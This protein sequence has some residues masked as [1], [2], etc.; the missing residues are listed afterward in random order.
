MYSFVTAPRT[1]RRRCFPRR[2]PCR[3]MVPMVVSWLVTAWSLIPQPVSAAAPARPNIVLIMADDF[4]YECLGCNGSLSYK[5]PVLDRLAAEGL[6]FTHC[7]AQ[8]LCT[9]SRVQMLTGRYNFRNYREFGWLDPNEIT[10]A[11]LLRDAGY[12][13]GIAGKWQLNGLNGRHADTGD[14]LRVVRAGFDEFCLWQLTQPRSAGERYADPLVEVRGAAPTI[15]K[16]KYGPDVFCDFV[17]DFI[18][19]HRDEPFLVY[20]PMVLTHDPFVPTPDSPDWN[21]RRNRKHVDNFPDMV[22]Y[23]DKNVGRI[24][25][26]LERL[27]LREKTLLIFTGDNGSPRQVVTQLA[28]GPFEGGKGLTLDSGCHVPLIVSWPGTAPRGAVRDDLI[29]FSDVLPTL[30]EVAGAKLPDDR[31]IDGRSFLPQLKGQPGTPRAW[32]FCHYDPA[33]GQLSRHRTRFARDRRYKLYHDG[34]LYDAQSDPRELTPLTD[35]P[36]LQPIRSKL[37]S[38]L[39]AMPPWTPLE[40]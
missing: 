29:D 18:E 32:V 21:T 36:A 14:P 22:A 17:V 27:K 4:G 28:S 5:T 11:N 33:W 13:T 24:I 31:E 20:Y 3:L 19:R 39:D 12:R 1:G 37:Q 6:R 16:D 35:D 38:A 2:S 25:A 10:F 23:A 30:V 7:Y 26:Q 9:P 15:L 40:E 34:R 8:P